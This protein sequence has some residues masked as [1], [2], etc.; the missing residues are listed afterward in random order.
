MEEIVEVIR[1][2]FAPGDFAEVARNNPSGMTKANKQLNWV[3]V[4]LAAGAISMVVWHYYD[5]YKEENRSL[6]K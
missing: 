2:G 4:I 3:I 6:I 5:K 1:D